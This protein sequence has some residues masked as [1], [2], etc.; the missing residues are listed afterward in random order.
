MPHK[1]NPVPL[2]Q[3]LAASATVPARVAS[4]LACMPSQ[5]ERGLGPW[6]AELAEWPQLVLA[7]HATLAALSEAL[8]TLAFDPARIQA[9]IDT[10]QGRLASEGLALALAPRFGRVQAQALVARWCAQLGPGQHLRD[11]AEASG[12]LPAA[13]LDALFDLQAIAAQADARAA[14]ALS[15]GAPDETGRL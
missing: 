15:A 5:L 14:R 12:E 4:L 6:Q 3:A 10:H 9:H 11:L 1:L 2:M 7:V 8:G 13:Q